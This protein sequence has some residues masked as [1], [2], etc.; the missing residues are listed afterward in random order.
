MSAGRFNKTA[1]YETLEATV[2][3]IKVQPETIT[4]WNPEPTGTSSGAFVRVGGSR[5][6]YGTTARLARFE[7]Q[8]APPAGYDIRGTIVL[9][10]LTTA[11]FNG[12]TF[13]T[14]YAYQG[15]A[16]RLLGRTPE[17]SR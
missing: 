15:G 2:R 5:R 1:K 9:P 12:L 10:I 14:D 8:G 7:W 11:A 3:P 6:K 13:G 17:R 4:A 16:L